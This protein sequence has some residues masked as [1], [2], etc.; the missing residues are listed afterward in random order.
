MN[1][2]LWF[3]VFY[4]LFFL[5]NTYCAIPYDALGPELTD[6]QDDRAVVFLFSNLYTMLGLLCGAS[7][8]LVVSGIA[9]VDNYEPCFGQFYNQPDFMYPQQISHNCMDKDF[10]PVSKFGDGWNVSAWITK[11]NASYYELLDDATLTK[12]PDLQGLTYP[13]QASEAHYKQKM[14]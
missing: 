5:T 6:D 4:I 2:S 10:G 12:Y 1:L 3:G 14:T 13:V 11:E 8:P 7:L 9:S